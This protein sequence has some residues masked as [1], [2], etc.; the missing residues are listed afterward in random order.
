VPQL[1]ILDLVLQKNRGEE[2]LKFMRN[3][4]KLAQVPVIV[5][6]AIGDTETKIKLMNLG[7]TRLPGLNPMIL[8]N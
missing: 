3:D 4:Q 7:A 1:V 6:T 8:V 2:L 5:S